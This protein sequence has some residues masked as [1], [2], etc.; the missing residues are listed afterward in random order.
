[1]PLA[2]CCPWAVLPR[3][4]KAFLGS[5]FETLS[6]LNLGF[7]CIKHPTQEVPASF[8]V[9][10]NNPDPKSGIFMKRPY[11]TRWGCIGSPCFF[12]D[13]RKDLEQGL[14]SYIKGIYGLIYP[15]IHIS[16]YVPYLF[17]PPFVR[18]SVY[19]SIYLSIYLSMYLLSIWTPKVCKTI[20][21]WGSVERPEAIICCIVG[22]QVK[23]NL[24]LGLLL[25]IVRDCCQVGLEAVTVTTSPFKGLSKKNT[26]GTSMMT[27]SVGSYT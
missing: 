22:D 9:S 3:R 4:P 14:R 17:T 24:D 27:N 19:L 20:A 1:M 16:V 21:L 6:R 5:Q 13:S 15:C 18:I 7:L 10:F 23:G 11:R 8:Q 2:L 25:C 12:W 26:V